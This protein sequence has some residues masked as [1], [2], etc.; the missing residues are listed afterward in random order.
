[1]NL[2][3]NKYLYYTVHDGSLWQIGLATE[4]PLTEPSQKIPLVIIPA[5]LPHG[6][7]QS[8]VYNQAVNPT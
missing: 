6:N 2:I 5:Y 4:K 1:L 3:N 8:L 7:K